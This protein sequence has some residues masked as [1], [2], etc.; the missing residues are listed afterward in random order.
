MQAQVKVINNI[1]LLTELIEPGQF[2]HAI[3]TQ[4]REVKVP[5][6]CE[7]IRAGGIIIDNG[8]KFEKFNFIAWAINNKPRIRSICLAL[9]VGF[10]LFEIKINTEQQKRI[11]IKVIDQ[12]KITA[13]FI[14]SRSRILNDEIIDITMQIRKIT[15]LSIFWRGIGSLDG[16]W[17]LTHK[18]L[19][20][21]N[22][23]VRFCT[24]YIL[25]YFFFLE[26]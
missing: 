10:S 22:S 4:V 3:D 1:S 5:I 19:I 25:I 16:N 6:P 2:M 17:P 15:K 13:G 23:N 9:I 12:A 20:F 11:S 8:L 26:L 18:I 24:E 14:G 7:I 21:F